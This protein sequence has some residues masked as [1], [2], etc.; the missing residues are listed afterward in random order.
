M[1]DDRADHR[2][3]SFTR[4]VT[5]PSQVGFGLPAQ[6]RKRLTQ[7]HPACGNLSAEAVSGEWSIRALP[8]SGKRIA[9][10][11]TR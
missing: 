10:R 1:D 7:P 4:A 2:F 11:E 9:R 3:G 5:L 6:Y 8:I